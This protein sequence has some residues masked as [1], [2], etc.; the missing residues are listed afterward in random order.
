MTTNDITLGFDPG[1]ENGFGCCVLRADRLRIKTVSSIKEAMSWAVAECGGDVPIS[2]GI[3]TL[4][5]WSDGSGGWRRADLTLR[6]TYPE[7]L[8][9]VIAP[10]SLYGAMVAGGVGLAIR[11]REHWPSITLTE[12]HP[13]VLFHTLRG[14][15][16]VAG[17]VGSAAIW[18][19]EKHG[20]PS[21][22]KLDEHQFDALISA[23][24]A[25]EGHNRCWC[26]LCEPLSNDMIFPAGPVSYL[27]PIAIG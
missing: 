21:P 7:V 22:E 2:A 6:K 27:W 25:R 24:V 13:K 17:D 18:F 5:H 10:N 14:S 20:L 26:D 1:G 15:R 11:L 8:K 4:L 9:S 23:W 16:Y 12:T 3:D 19:A